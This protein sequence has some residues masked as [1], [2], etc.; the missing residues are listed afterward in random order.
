MQGIGRILAG[1]ALLAGAIVAPSN[2]DRAWAQSTQSPADD[3]AFAVPRI[4]PPFGG[5]VPLPTPLAPSEAAQVRRVYDLQKAGAYTLAARES[6]LLG[7]NLLLGHL[8]ADRLLRQGR[9]APVGDL[10]AWL[11]AYADH[12]EAPAVYALLLRAAPKGQSIPAAPQVPM[13]APELPGSATPEEIDQLSSG[14]TRS[15][16]LEAELLTCVRRGNPHAA[17]ALLRRSGW[18]SS[19]YATMLRADIARALFT[20]N[21]D[22][23]AIEVATSAWDQDRR[24]GLPAYLAGLASWRMGELASSRRWFEAAADAPSNTASLQA[25]AAFWAARAAQKLRDHAAAQVWLGRAAAEP[26]TFY[27]LLANRLLGRPAGLDWGN[28]VLG[29]ADVEAIDATPQ[30]ARAFALLQVGQDAEAEAEFRALW[31]TLQGSPTMQRALL[32]VCDQARLSGLTAQL[33][34]LLQTPDGGA[35]D[36]ARFPVP[37]LRPTGGFTVNRPLVYALAR[38]ES[39]FQSDLVSPAGAL[40]LL[41]MTPVAASYVTGRQGTYP[42]ALLDPALNLD[43]GQRYLIYLSNTGAVNEDLVRLLAAY[44]AGVGAVSHWDI[45]DH[46]D[47]LLYIEAIPTG[48]TREFV[49]RAL[50]YSWIYAARFHQSS[51]SLDTLAAGA[52]PQFPVRTL[53]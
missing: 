32:R 41:Q 1:A 39:N 33:A 49:P 22:E 18:I 26:R 27:G 36:L 6:A 44:N 8:R 46:G 30:G 40:G 53:H 23:A 19:G 20:Q 51:D 12:P 3:T 28:E 29:E 21:Q 52:W 25:G 42:M 35:N 24:F 10:K 34:A 15:P 5:N 4:T 13:L 38:V 9:R 14:I 2:R 37:T 47:P 7:N 17:E 48:Q 45:E 16:A 11:A 50:A 31:P 43:I